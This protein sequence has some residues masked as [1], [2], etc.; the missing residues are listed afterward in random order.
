MVVYL[1][2]MDLHYEQQTIICV[3]KTRELAI[4]RARGLKRTHGKLYNFTEREIEGSPDY[5]IEGDGL[6]FNVYETEVE[7]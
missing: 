7:E 4:T 6:S 1:V 5:Y 2:E 3:C